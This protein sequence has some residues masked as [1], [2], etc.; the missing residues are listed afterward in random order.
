MED[1]TTI[2]EYL[3]SGA[4]SRIVKHRKSPLAGIIVFICGVVLLWVS[5]RTRLSD[6]LQMSLLTIGACAAITGFLMVVMTYVSGDGRYIFTPTRAKI[7]HHS[8]YINADDRQMLKD[9]LSDGNLT[10]L[11]RVRK[12]VSTGTLLQAYVSTDGSLGLLQL[13]EYIPHNFMPAT[14]VVT[15]QPEYIPILE[16]WLKQ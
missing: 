6:T 14:A 1:F 5:L 15:V 12:E 3:D 13:E 7:K 4:N 2:K 9:M 16:S 10:A 8:K 11:P